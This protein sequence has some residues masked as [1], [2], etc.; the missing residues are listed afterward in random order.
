[1][2]VPIPT[3]PCELTK[4][5]VV[6]PVW[7]EVEMTN[8]FRFEKVEVAEIASLAQGVVVDM[9]SEAGVAFQK[10]FELSCV[11]RPLAPMNGTEP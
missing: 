2:V 11:R 7:V 6:V 10:K 3:L 8:R 4:K 1:M 9:P 5:A